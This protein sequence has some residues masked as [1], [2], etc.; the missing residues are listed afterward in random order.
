MEARGLKTQQLRPS[1]HDTRFHPHV[2]SKSTDD[3]SICTYIPIFLLRLWGSTGASF[4]ILRR[5]V[6][7]LL[8][9]SIL[10]LK[11][12]LNAKLLSLQA[13]LRAWAVS[14]GAREGLLRPGNGGDPPSV[15]RQDVDP[16]PVH[17]QACR[18]T[19]KVKGPRLSSKFLLRKSRADRE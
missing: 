3:K 14:E 18:A 5:Y 7:T 10:V 4:P 13:G 2:Q 6:A 12:M 1:P 16:N 17:T 15:G 8:E 19:R 9:G 11:D